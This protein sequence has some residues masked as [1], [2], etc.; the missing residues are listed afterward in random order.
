MPLCEPCH[1]CTLSRTAAAS[2][3]AEK[4]AACRLERPLS[5]HV[6]GADMVA[7]E[8]LLTLLPVGAAPDGGRRR[9]LR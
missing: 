2:C 5:A 9:E 4:Q 7:S 8:E 3:C 6:D 1:R